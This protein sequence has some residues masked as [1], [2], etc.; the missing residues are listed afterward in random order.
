[1]RQGS[2]RTIQQVVFPP[3]YALANAILNFGANYLMFSIEGEGK[4]WPRPLVFPASAFLAACTFW[5]AWYFPVPS[6]Q[7]NEFMAHME[8][9]I[10]EQAERDV[11][12]RRLLQNSD[13]LEAGG[14]HLEQRR[15][16]EIDALVQK[17]SDRLVFAQTGSALM[18]RS[19][20]MPVLTLSFFLISCANALGVAPE[21]YSASELLMVAS[22]TSLMSTVLLLVFSVLCPVLVSFQKMDPPEFVSPPNTL[23]NALR[24]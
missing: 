14:H 13:D 12:Y 19:L 24:R 22:V 9:G 16:E 6:F 7:H 20:F 23:L 1:M 11:D 10:R 15:Q 21:E 2:I 4:A 17:R 3:S 18:I 8:A 5:T